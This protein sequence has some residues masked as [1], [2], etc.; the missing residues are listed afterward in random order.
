MEKEQE[1]LLWPVPGSVE[2]A[3]SEKGRLERER[4]KVQGQVQ[5]QVVEVRGVVLEV[6]LK[7]LK[8]KG[9]GKG[10]AN[11]DTRT[12]GLCGLSLG[13]GRQR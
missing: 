8:N 11:F 13:R 10:E 5:G 2:V 3:S 12:E 6:V 1:Q 7:I 9:E 4:G